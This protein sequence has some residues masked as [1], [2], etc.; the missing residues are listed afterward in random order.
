MDDLIKRA[1]AIEEISKGVWNVHE[2]IDRISALPSA[3][4]EQE[5]VP[6][7]VRVTMSD[8]SQYYLEQERDTT[9]F[10]AVQG[11]WVRKVKEYND[12]DGHRVVYWYECDQCGARPPKDTWRNEW[13]SN[14]C[15][16]CGAYM[17]KKG[18]AE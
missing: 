15:P 11:E 9:Q 10:D 7:V 16:S 6:T 8:G 18:G 14:F 3:D 13:H 4:A 2:L 17:G 12:C 5:A 1:D